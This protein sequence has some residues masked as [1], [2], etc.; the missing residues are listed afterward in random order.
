MTI[1]PIDLSG[2]KS[3]YCFNEN[4]LKSAR[5]LAYDNPDTAPKIQA[6]LQRV[7]SELTRNERASLAF[8]IIERLRESS[9]D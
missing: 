2:G 8:M 1:R 7:E 3:V 4:Q 9:A 5:E 6:A